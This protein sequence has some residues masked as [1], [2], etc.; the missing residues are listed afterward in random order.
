LVYLTGPAFAYRKILVPVYQRILAPISQIFQNV[1]RFYYVRLLFASIYEVV[2]PLSR[3]VGVT[4]EFYGHLTKEAMLRA[5]P[6]LEKLFRF[7][8]LEVPWGVKASFVP[9]MKAL[10]GATPWLF[11]VVPVKLY[12][13]VFMPNYR[14]RRIQHFLFASKPNF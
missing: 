3:A 9:A 5:A 12:H 4:A 6:V 8:F 10:L 14:V 7:Y 1:L 11:F 2:V 13:E